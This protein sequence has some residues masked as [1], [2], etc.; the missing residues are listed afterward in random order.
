MVVV[1][2][3]TKKVEVLGAFDLPVEVD[4]DLWEGLERAFLEFVPD[5]L[6]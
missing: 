6:A 1:A 4:S 5:K 3:H 2:D